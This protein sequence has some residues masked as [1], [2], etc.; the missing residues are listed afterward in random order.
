LPS[1]SP[2][3]EVSMTNPGLSHILEEI[4]KPYPRVVPPDP[5]RPSPGT[6]LVT[7]RNN[8]SVPIT[9]VSLGSNSQDWARMY[10]PQIAP[11][12]VY[13]WEMRQGFCSFWLKIEFADGQER[14]RLVE[15]ACTTSTLNALG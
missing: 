12:S 1:V 9:G 10:A 2:R 5:A 14:V 13:H 11:G 8:H 15:D 4:I 6:Y 3:Q 7:V